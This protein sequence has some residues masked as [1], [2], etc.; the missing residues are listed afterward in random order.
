MEAR[1]NV[2]EVAK[3]NIVKAQ[4][5][6][7]KQYDKK[8]FQPEVFSV[9]AIVLKKDFTRKK[10]K[11]GKLD[12][13]WVDPYRIEAALGRGLYRLQEVADSTKKIER[14]NGCHLKQYN[15]RTL[16]S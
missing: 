2:L 16:S 8:H 9:G 7:K 15:V 11:G 4:M 1:E 5:K 12:D 3:A 13:K 14:V 10:R 6:Q